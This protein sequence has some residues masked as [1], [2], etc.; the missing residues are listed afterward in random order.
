MLVFF[1]LLLEWFETYTNC[2]NTHYYIYYF[3]DLF[4]CYVLM[5]RC[6]WNGIFLV[7][8]GGIYAEFMI[9]SRQFYCFI[10]VL[11]VWQRKLVAS[12]IHQRHTLVIESHVYRVFLIITKCSYST[13]FTNITL[14]CTTLNSMSTG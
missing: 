3:W 12:F 10:F 7:I 4:I 8:T 9:I 6:N 1:S 11:H 14:L 5:L 13:D 2:N